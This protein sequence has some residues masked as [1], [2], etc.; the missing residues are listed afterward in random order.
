MI[1]YICEKPAQ[2]RDIARNLK[3]TERKDGYLE[4]NG[5]Q[6][7]WCV[8]H[9]LELAPPEYYKSDLR[10]WRIE[11]LPVIPDTWK[12]LI[13]PRTKKQ[14]NTIK[15]LLKNTQHVVVAGDPDRAGEAII[16]EILDYC[17]YQGKIERLWLSALDDVS[18]QKALNTLKSGDETIMLYEAEKSR[19]ASDYL[20]GLNLTMAASA[21]YGVN[22]VLSIGRV[23]TPTLRLVVDRDRSIENFIPKDYFILKTLFSSDQLTAFWTTWQ[24]PENLQDE[25]GHCLNK[26]AV[27]NVAAK[28]DD[29]PGTIKS[30]KEKIKKQKSPL[31]FALSDLQKKAS[32]LFGYSAKQVLELAQSLYETHKA[33]S[34]PRT[35]CGYLPVE[36]LEEV[37]QVFSALSQADHEIKTLVA[38]CDVQFQS[39]VWNN[40]KITA[41]HSIIPTMNEQVDI[42]RMSQEELNVYDLIRRQ[43]LAQFLGD[44]EYQQHQVEVACAGEIFTATGNTLIKPGWKQAFKRMANDEREE[45]EKK[46]DNRTIP[47]LS[48]GQAVENQETTVENKQTKPLARFTEGTLIDAMKTVGK[49]VEDEALKKILKDSSGIGTEATRANI[50]ETLFKRAYLQRKTKQVI[51]TDK[52]RA[53][54]DLVPEAIKNPLLTAQWEERLEDIVKGHSDFNTFVA[55]QVTL[56]KEMLVQLQSEE[57]KKQ[58]AIL[59]LQSNT[60]NGKV[61]LCPKCQSSL[62]QLKSKK[63]KYFWGCGKYPGCDFTTWEKNEKPSL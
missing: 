49:F 57:T 63:G 36:Q 10:P 44:Y 54:I 51:S 1:L 50:L 8:G 11:K 3:A 52:G 14:F 17:H 47:T 33:T 6:V 24:V 56:L 38:L 39:S 15:K 7:T 60:H 28:V 34:Y 41:H 61:Y 5:Y 4:G 22:G 13:T 58:A 27:E 29:E 12:M 35:D 42:G 45:D 23:Q 26:H 62:R 18:I 30:F 2:A 43:Y 21:L 40:K 9:L 37:N 19:A 32:A 53:L 16:R 55:A 48:K 20:L 31:C 25:S 59:Q 46:E